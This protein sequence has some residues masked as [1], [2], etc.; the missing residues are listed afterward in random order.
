[1]ENQI[2]L[3][4]YKKCPKPSKQPTYKFLKFF[5]FEKP[6]QKKIEWFP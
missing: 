3:T 2:F 5:M 4:F 1:M 6:P